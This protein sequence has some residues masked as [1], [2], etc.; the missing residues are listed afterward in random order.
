MALDDLI[1]FEEP[2]NPFELF[3]GRQSPTAAGVQRGVCRL[4]GAMGYAAITEMPL[5]TGRRVDV[6][7]LGAKGEI[8]VI[9]I[10]SSHTDYRTD[11]KWQDY[12]AFC[13][14]FFFAVPPDFPREVL[15]DDVGLIV[16]DRYGAEVLR[17]AETV[18]LA[19]ARRKAMTLLFA[20]IAARRVHGLID[21]DA[22]PLTPSEL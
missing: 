13:D 11:Q 19:G 5:S 4:L 22:A 1:G 8:V 15:P 12:L 10:K 3:D 20:R 9:E 7:A 14:R 16:A 21:R 2:D 18:K 17:E 6:I